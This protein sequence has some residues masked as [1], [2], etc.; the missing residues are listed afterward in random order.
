MPE[1]AEIGHHANQDAETT[2][3]GPKP[4]D[5]GKVGSTDAQA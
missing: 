2:V 3:P 4:I 1:G 5:S